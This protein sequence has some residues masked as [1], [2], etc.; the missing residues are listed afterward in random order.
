MGRSKHSRITRLKCAAAA[1]VLA[2]TVSLPDSA[3]AQTQIEFRIE[4]GS[5]RDAL[6]AYARVTRRQLLYPSSLVAG[7]TASS[8]RGRYSRDEALRRL[9]AG[10][11]IRF[12]RAGNAFV[13]IPPARTQ[14]V[15]REPRP[16]RRNPPAARRSPPNPPQPLAPED[17]EEESIVVTGSNI[18]GQT[19]GPSP[20]QILD[21][22]EIER[23]GQGTVAEAIAALPQNFGGTGTEDTI[24]TG[25]DRTIQ[26]SGLS[27]S[28]NLRG[29][30]SDATLTL[31]NGRR[32]PGAGSNGDFSD[33]SLVP[34][35]AVERI[36]VLTDGASAIYGSD[37]VGG[38][39]NIILRR[40]LR[41]AETRLR[42]GSV[43]QGDT[44]EVQFGQVVG[45]EWAGGSLIA[46]YE[47]QNR[48]A[49]ATD[50]RDFTSTADLRARGGSDF[51]TF[52]SNPGTVIG[53]DPATGALVA[54]Y[55]IPA[56]QE[57]TALTPADFRPGANLSSAITGSNI[58]PHQIRHSG[59]ALL[60]QEVAPGAE[61]FVEARYGN[62]RFRYSSPAA[63]DVVQVTPDN[64]FFVS[65]DG[66]PFSL[67]AYSFIN[68]LG[69]V[70]NRGSVEAWSATGGAT[71][72]LS[73][74][75][76]L[77]SFVSF[78]RE[79]T[80]S[81]NDN[82]VN[83][84]YLAEASGALPDDPSTPFSTARDGFFNPY[85]E[86][87]INSAAVLDFVG[88]G[89]GEE[90]IRSSLLSANVKADGRLFE[91]PGGSVRAALGAAFRREFFERGGEFLLFGTSPLALVQ[92]DTSRS[93]AALF[94]EVTI[95]VFGPGNARPGLQ[96]LEFSAAV[97]YER[98]SDFGSSTNPRLGVVWEPA[99]GFRVR[100][101]FGTSFRAPALR[102]VND[103]L[104]VSATQ[105]R[106]A[107]G[108]LNT[109]I[110]LNGGNPDLGPERA[111][112]L[113]LG[114][115]F[116]PTAIR[117]LRGEVTFF[118]TR[119]SERI[120]QPAFEDSQFVLRDSAYSPFVTRIDPANNPAD[121]AR[122]L[123]LIATPGSGIPAFIPPEL[124]QAIVDGRYVNTSQLLVRGLDFILSHRFGLAGGE[125]SATLNASYLIDYQRQAT[126]VS[127]RVER[128][129][130]I[131]N[132]P[133]LRLRASGNWDR[134]P[135]GFSATLN[136][137][138]G[139]RDDVSVPARSVDAWLTV[140]A[141]IRLRPNW[142]GW[143][144]DM[145]FSLSAQNLF[146]ADPPFVNRSP[147][148]AYDATN[149]DPLGR[150]VALQ[151]IK[152]W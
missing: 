14:P 70:R 47:Y 149:A 48:E 5:L 53:F 122:V 142:R 60:T 109:V 17:D 115:Q 44:Q 27:S 12:R 13:L 80:W 98:H 22:E 141:Q 99:A 67:I 77:D 4:G 86:G 113:T 103:P 139:Y 63:F 57:G 36:E 74:D 129:D 138:D 134:G 106:D 58:L 96:R 121:R 49:L 79:Q 20:V 10:T 85:G 61:L 104:G 71:V 107:D 45:V 81:R 112:S 69:P 26:N 118:Q 19:E 7:R 18:R 145:S 50:D 39:I 119:F 89:F 101:S 94:G 9:L 62:R 30:G 124:F 6:T 137:V 78:A 40:N 90:Q 52:F 83:S 35:A 37:A 91:M 56:G 54:Q 41:G 34:L 140:D 31:L 95:P 33:L 38:V 120:G 11:G 88:Q 1:L 84:T 146:D 2:V 72:E 111:R 123:E 29:L 117:G 132:P 126:P 130:T 150:F 28:A 152:T 105:L 65:P 100:G 75:W 21:R 116:A 55:A 102:E 148:L 92:A 82:L 133:D 108:N 110:F 51:R 16:P 43:T 114:V 24:L 66:S 76:L 127:S 97:R 68:E 87:A 23:A 42:V 147:G 131:G 144:R 32:L 59:Y 64:P 143:M 73:G 3:T 8:L 135:W 151:I 136:Y 125:A 46:A 15:A 93:V 128:V 25:S